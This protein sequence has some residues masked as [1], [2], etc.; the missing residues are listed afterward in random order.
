MGLQNA[1][2]DGQGYT[3]KNF[4]TYFG[5]FPTI[6]NSTVR[7]VGITGKILGSSSVSSLV[8]R[9]ALKSNLENVYVKLT[10]WNGA[11]AGSPV[12]ATL[13][14]TTMKNCMVETVTL[15]STKWNE[16]CS[17]YHNNAIASISA[18]TSVG[19]FKTNTFTDCYV[20]S[21]MPLNMSIARSAGGSYRGSSTVYNIPQT[22]T[23]H[24]DKTY[25]VGSDNGYGVYG[26]VEGLNTIVDTLAE[27]DIQADDEYLKTELS[28]TK[29]EDGTKTRA[30]TMTHYN[31]G[32][33]IKTPEKVEFNLTL[34]ANVKTTKKCYYT[35]KSV[36][37][38]YVYRYF[39]YT[40][41]TQIGKDDRNTIKRYDTAAKMRE[42]VDSNSNLADFNGKYWT[43]S[44]G[45]LKWKTA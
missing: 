26:H 31:S 2:F 39:D 11:G 19:D 24:N 8:A 35:N 13:A 44:S 3:I 32:S 21:G 4:S 30:V 27:S 23:A 38:A 17:S 41:Y 29:N 37:G 5:V 28:Q 14:N 43:N 7:N 33:P 34:A 10:G 16:N 40:G 18:Y 12:A 20:V 25:G 9:H 1:I 36:N 15:A 42:D 45:Y 6:N 22:F